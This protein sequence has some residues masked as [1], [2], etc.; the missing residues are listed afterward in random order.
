MY[1]FICIKTELKKVIKKEEDWTEMICMVQK[2]K[3]HT[4]YV[5]STQPVTDLTGENSRPMAESSSGGCRRQP[6]P[7]TLFYSCIKQS[8]VTCISLPPDGHVLN[9]QAKHLQLLLMSQTVHCSKFAYADCVYWI[10]WH[11]QLSY[12]FRALWQFHW[13]VQNW[14][15]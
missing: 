10:W 5:Y 7:R 15:S 3:P 12:C 8:T 6:R 14:I 2:N 1:M 4:I 13:Q 11:M 9:L